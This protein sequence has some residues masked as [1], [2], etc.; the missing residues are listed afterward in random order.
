[1]SFSLVLRTAIVAIVVGA[2]SLAPVGIGVSASAAS[3][4]TPVAASITGSSAA[5]T[6]LSADEVIMNIRQEYLLTTQVGYKAGKV[7]TVE[8][9]TL[10]ND[11]FS[12]IGRLNFSVIPRAVSGTFTLVGD[13]MVNGTPASVSW[14]TN[15]NL[16]VDLA[17]PLAPQG[18]A[19]IKIEFALQLHAGSGNF[20]ARFSLTAGVL[21]L[22]NWFP[23]LSREHD[24]YGIGDPQVTW[25]AKRIT[26][27]LR[28]DENL[29][30]TAI[31]APGTLVK[32]AT[33]HW[34]YRLDNARD[35]AFAISSNFTR[36]TATVSGVRIEAYTT[37]G[38]APALLAIMKAAVSRYTGWYGSMPYNRFIIAETGASDFAQEYPGMVLA[39]PNMVG[40]SPAMWHEVAHQW[41]YAGVGDDQLVSPW[42]DEAFAEFSARRALGMAFPTCSSGNIDSAVTDWPAGLT[43]GAWLGCGRYF[44]TVYMRGAAF[45]NAL[46]SQ[47]GEAKFFKTLK[48]FATSHRYAMVTSDEML[49]ALIAGGASTSIIAKYTSR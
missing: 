22:G 46:R 41:W 26:L 11:S 43:D 25:V 1:M 48:A 14:T 21:N 37:R 15:T 31:A 36:R 44:D 35:Y 38:S 20:P 8:T 33:R 42:L 4:P 45:L 24:A 12:D 13:V 40:Y 10:H 5:A 49:D 2:A 29:A 18:T 30:S 9:V 6:G 28:T 47:M 27:D 17:T 19:T 34:T 23:I 3:L 39:G 32:S 7:R 16:A